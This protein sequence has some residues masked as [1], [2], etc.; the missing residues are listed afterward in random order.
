MALTP[1]EAFDHFLNWYSERNSRL[2]N[3]VQQA[4]YARMGKTKHPLG[5]KRIRA[6]LEKYA[7]ERYRFTEVVEVIVAD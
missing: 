6:L 4:K 7:P 5:S 1:A 2:P 3:D